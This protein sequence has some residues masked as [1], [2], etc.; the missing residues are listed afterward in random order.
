LDQADLGLG[1]PLRVA[2]IGATVGDHAVD[3]VGRRLVEVDD[4]KMRP[5]NTSGWKTVANNCLKPATAPRGTADGSAPESFGHL[6]GSG[7]T[8]KKGAGRVSATVETD[9]GHGRGQLSD[10]RQYRNYG[11][12]LRDALHIFPFE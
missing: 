9:P 12:Q 10:P 11:R 5:A 6:N 8:A 1:Q 7:R 3:I 4:G 2:E